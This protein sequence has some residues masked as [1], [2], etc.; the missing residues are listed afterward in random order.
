[1]LAGGLDFREVVLAVQNIAGGFD[2]V[3]ATSTPAR[4]I[5]ST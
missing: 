4:F 1:V 5:R 3:R 2:P